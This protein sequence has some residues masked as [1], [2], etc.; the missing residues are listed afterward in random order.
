MTETTK[1]NRTPREAETRGS[2]ARRKPWSPPSRLMHL[3]HL[4][5]TSIV[6][7]VQK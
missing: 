3:Q 1:T 5:D 2:D 7:F 4:L 6:G